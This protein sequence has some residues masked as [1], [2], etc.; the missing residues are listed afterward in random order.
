MTKNN[1][2]PVAVITGILGQDGSY[3]AQL[4]LQQ[5]YIVYGTV[6]TGSVFSNHDFLGIT[7]RVHYIPCDLDNETQVADSIRTIKPDELYHLGGLSA[8]GESWSQPVAYAQTNALGTLYLLDAV[9]RYSP[10]TKIVHAATSEMFGDQHQKGLQTEET[11]FHPTNPY[12]VTKMFSYWMGN[13]Y[14]QGYSLFIANAILFSHE[15]PLRGEHFVTRKI[16]QGV[17]KIKLGQAKELVLG[18]IESQRDWGFAGDYVKAMWLIMQHHTADDFII[19]TGKVHTIREFLAMA[20]ATVGITDWSRYVRIDSA[21]YR[22]IDLPNLSGVSDKA[23][24]LLGWQPTTT[25]AELVK[26]MVEADIQRLQ[27]KGK[28]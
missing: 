10:D 16:T 22:P 9:R 6:R 21:L 1:I 5:G 23:H 28:E 25:F 8:P 24:R 2:Q 12:A 17:A 13:I 20:F 7:S 4:L 11:P 26:L 27:K 15:S 18:N 14:R 3:L 19:S